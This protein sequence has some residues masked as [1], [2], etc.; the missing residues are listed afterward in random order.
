MQTVGIAEF[1][2]GTNGGLTLVNYRLTEL[3][4]DPVADATRLAQVKLAI[5]ESLQ[6][7]KVQGAKTNYAIPSQHVFTRFVKLPAV[8]EEKA[9]QIVAFEAQQNVPF[10]IDE[11]VWDYQ[12]VGDKSA[13]NLEVVLVAIKSDLLEE[14][15]DV[16]EENALTPSVV[17]VAPMALYNAFRYNYS[18]VQGCSLIIDIGA[19]TTDLIFVEPKKVFSRSISIGGNTIT[20]AIAKE[21]DEPFAT[22]EE[23]KKKD[24]FVNLGGAYAEPSDPDVA[25]VSKMVRNTMTRLHAEISRSI[26]FYRSQQGGSAPQQVYLSGGSVS[27]T[28]MREFFNEKLRVQVEFFNALRNVSVASTVNASE[29]GRSAH[30][31]GELVGLGLRG[32]I[33]CPMELNLRPA[34]VVKAAQM[35]RRQPALIMAAICL[36]LALFA[37]SAYFWKASSLERAELSH[38]NPKVTELQGFETKMNK[39]RSEVKVEE[40][41][42]APYVQAVQDRSYWVKLIDD[43]NSRLPARNI[44]VTDFEVGTVDL[45]SAREHFTS[46]SGK[47]QT[48]KLGYAS[49]KG[50]SVPCVLVKGLYIGNNSNVIDE[51]LKNISESPYFKIDLTEKSK[52]NP[53]HASP[54]SNDWAYGYTFYLP[55]KIVIG[56]Q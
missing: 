10:P 4:A 30:V 3:L 34:S 20:A 12:L 47:R 41:E 44:W 45:D 23:R 29:V 32:D 40:K 31:L 39:V 42:S 54:N 1:R 15:N 21:F 18:D 50:Q 13:S 48:A 28:Y 7:L 5:G 19:R 24:G 9:D 38:L 6:S 26:S 25:R 56:E 17:D 22:A 51:F 55:L 2:A 37:G 49:A 14:T 27:L 52:Y 33:A 53:V 11:V 46:G 36:F 43:V 35:R 8:G 16:V